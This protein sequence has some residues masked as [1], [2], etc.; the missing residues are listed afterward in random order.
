MG[1]Q[2]MKR[3]SK[4]IIVFVFASM[5]VSCATHEVKRLE[6]RDPIVKKLEEHDSLRVIKRTDSIK[7][8]STSVNNNK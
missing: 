3:T 1:R 4:I 5:L 2:K 8:S 6:E 7:K